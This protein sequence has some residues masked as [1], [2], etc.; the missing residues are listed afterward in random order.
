VFA[1]GIDSVMEARLGG[2][3]RNIQDGGTFF[4][5]KA[6]LVV[7]QEDRPAGWR[8]VVEKVQ[9]DLVGQLG[10]TRIRRSELF[11][12][13]VVEGLPAAGAFEMREGNARGDPEA[14]RTKD[15]GFA[16]E[17]KLAEYLDR[18]LLENIVSE[19]DAS[20]PDDV[21]AQ[22]RVDV[23]EELFQSGPVAALGKKDKESLV[24]L[25]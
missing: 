3:D 14:P 10:G 13:Q 11:G 21:T 16:Q 1:K 6:V 12:G 9:E 7:E 17:W 2:A 15:G 4:E 22:R 23:M 19:C 20:Q 18:G 25:R 5:G 8:N 24:G